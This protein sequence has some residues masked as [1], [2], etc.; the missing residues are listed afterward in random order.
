MKSSASAAR[1]RHR[2]QHRRA[3]PP[4]TAS[5]QTTNAPNGTRNASEPNSVTTR[6]N[7]VRP[8]DAKL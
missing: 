6:K 7:Q 5:R 4:A 8:G 2:E 3:A 1:R